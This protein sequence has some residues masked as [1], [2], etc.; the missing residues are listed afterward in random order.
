MQVEQLKKITEDLLDPFFEAGEEAKRYIKKGIKITIKQDKSPVT[1]GDIAVDK[2]LRTNISKITPNIPIISEETV[3]LKVE[4]SFKTFWLIDPIDGTREYIKKKDEYTLNAALIIDKKPAIGIIFAPEKKR[5]FF[6]YGDQK[7]YQIIDNKEVI[8]SCQKKT[9]KNKVFALTN[10]T[11]PS[12][13]VLKI[14]K[15]NNANDFTKVSSSYKFCLIAAGEADIY[16]CRARAYEWDIAAG[17]AIVKHAGGIFQNIN[18]E[19]I[20]YGKKDY[21]NPPLLVKRSEQLLI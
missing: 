7:A 9:K 11:E 3:N 21:K 4:N 6:S 14:L 12:E 15:K 1:D 5:M 10:S 8:L 19:E 18:G 2:I 17:H 16:T 13:D 20:L